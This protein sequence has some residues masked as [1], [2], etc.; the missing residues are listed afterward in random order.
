M[1]RR[2]GR[3]FLASGFLIAVL[4]IAFFVSENGIMEPGKLGKGRQKL[5]C[6]VDVGADNCPPCARMKPVLEELKKEYAGVLVVELVD[7][8]KNPEAGQQYGVRSVPTQIFY[9]VNGKELKRHLGF[10]SKQDIVDEFQKLGISLKPANKKG[11]Q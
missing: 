11:A 9:D 7:A 2:T 10:I 4:M 1:T 6:L 8:G 3:I 5:P